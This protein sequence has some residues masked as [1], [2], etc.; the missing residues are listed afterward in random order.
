MAE[1]KAHGKGHAAPVAG[2]DPAQLS[3]SS[4]KLLE[5]S[6]ELFQAFSPQP[7]AI[8]DLPQV[9]IDSPHIAEACRVAKDDPRLDFRR[10]L[11]LACVDY[12]EYLQLVYILHSIG[13]EQTLVIKTNVPAE[14]P[15]LPS[16]TSV[17]R[18]AGWYERE[19]HD[20]F[21][22]NFAGHPNLAPLLL[23]DSFEG[24]PG[25]KEFPF[26]EYQEF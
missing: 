17:W 2:G 16:V 11:C 7:G 23:Y 6:R 24:H 4:Q 5:T 9:V 1:A 3:Q 15:Q 22:V 26:H 12:R 13:R 21:G 10:L 25:R 19:A 8:F 18:A 14:N 20:L